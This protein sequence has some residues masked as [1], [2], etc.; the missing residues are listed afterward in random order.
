MNAPKDDKLLLILLKKISDWCQDDEILQCRSL[1][2]SDWSLGQ[3]CDHILKADR[4]NL[5]AI[6]V[7]M[8]GGGEPIDSMRK[9]HPVFQSGEIPRG[10]A[11]APDFVLPTEDPRS[12]DLEPLSGRVFTGWK[13]MLAEWQVG[14]GS[15]HNLEMGISHHEMGILNIPG[16][17]RFAEIHTRHHVCIMEDILNRK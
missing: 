10:V 2:I 14:A 9:T 8:R 5:R 3:H 15:G 1:E 12:E 16:W 6:E 4:L 13:E 11:K 7:L 17:I